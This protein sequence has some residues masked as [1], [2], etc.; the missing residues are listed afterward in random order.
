MSSFS[1]CGGSHVR[2]YFYPEVKK[3]KLLISSWPCFNCCIKINWLLSIL[4]EDLFPSK[5]CRRLQDIMRVSKI[6]CLCLKN[7]QK[8]SVSPLKRE[9]QRKW[10]CHIIAVDIMKCL[11][12]H[13]E[14]PQ[15]ISDIVRVFMCWMVAR[16]SPKVKFGD[17]QYSVSPKDKGQWVT[18]EKSWL[19]RSA[20][21]AEQDCS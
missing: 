17:R 14:F 19:T 2:L 4:Q 20:C 7:L 5:A 15:Q 9:A 11:C 6:P 16:R 8:C 12:G 13:Q 10:S 21:R 1:Q 18:M 3:K